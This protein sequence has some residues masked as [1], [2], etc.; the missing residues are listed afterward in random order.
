MEKFGQWDLARALTNN[1]GRD[2]MDTAN[3]G[4]AEVGLMAEKMAKKWIRSQPGTWAELSPEYAKRKQKKGLSNKTLIAT[5]SMI[6]SISSW[7]NKKGA[8]AGLKR[9]VSRPDG[10][11]P[12]LIGKIMEFGS[13][14]QNIPPRATWGP[15]HKQMKRKIVRE[16]LFTKFFMKKIR[17]RGI[18]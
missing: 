13:V 14:V 9:T 7:S 5:S 15:V 8:Y 16:K 2:M 10:A 1:L 12:I 6:Q 11:D 3:L 17:K 4:F 18:K